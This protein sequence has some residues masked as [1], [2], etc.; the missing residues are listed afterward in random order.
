MSSYEDPLLCT[1]QQEILPAV[2]NI[3]FTRALVERLPRDTSL[4]VD[5]VNPGLCHSQVTIFRVP[6][7]ITYSL[8]NQLGREIETRINFVLRF[9]IT[10]IMNAIARTTETGSRTLVNAAL[11]RTNKDIQGKYLNKCQIEEES[12]LVVSK[13]G[14][15]LQDRVWVSD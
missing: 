10:S 6:Q 14:K 15:V 9:I 12:D 11:E 8:R 4:G 3:F 1:H 13:E 7:H 2:F 5:A